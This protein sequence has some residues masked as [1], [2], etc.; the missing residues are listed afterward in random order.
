MKTVEVDIAVPDGVQLIIG[1]SHFIKS[2]E[3]LYEAL[4]TS[5]PG[6]RFGLAFCEASGS[7]LIRLE[8]NDATLT[9]LA[10]D[11]AARVAA[12]HSFVIVLKEAYPINVLNR[13]KAVDEVVNIFCATSNPVKVIVA[14]SESGRGILGVIDG[15]IPKGV[16]RDADREERKALLRKIGYKR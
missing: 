8:G 5:M 14:E 1:Q 16:E 13:V 4:A 10:R 9:D 11:F 7:A 2:V 15:V 3:D 12:G 6:I